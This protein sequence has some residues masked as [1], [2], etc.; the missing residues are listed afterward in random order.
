MNYDL[1][2]GSSPFKDFH[3]PRW[4]ELPSLDL[5]MDQ[6]L[7]YLNEQLAVFSEK[8]KPLLTSSMVNNY[9]KNSIVKPPVKKHYKSYHLAYLIVV[10]LMKQCFSVAQVA[11]M[12]QIYS[13][14][15]E[16]DR[17]A[18]DYDKFVTVFEDCL[19]DVFETGLC[20]KT[21]FENPTPEQDLMVDVIRTLA[22]KLSTEYKLALIQESKTERT[23]S[24]EQ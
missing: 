10:V 22:Y 2:A 14:I 8:D 15:E 12:I 19:Q 20:T 4:E 5:Y 21:Y 1:K 16:K 24:D 11:E 18:R 6:L 3:A 17:L 7:S 13:D 23:D 9:V